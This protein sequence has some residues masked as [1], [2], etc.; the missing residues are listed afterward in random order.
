MYIVY[1]HHKLL[2]LLTSSSDIMSFSTPSEEFMFMMENNKN[3]TQP[4]IFNINKRQRRSTPG[5]IDDDDENAVLYIKYGTASQVSDIASF[6]ENPCMPQNRVT[7]TAN[8][9]PVI[10]DCPRDSENNYNLNPQSHEL[11]ADHTTDIEA[12]KPYPFLPFIRIINAKYE[13]PTHGGEVLDMGSTNLMRG[14]CSMNGIPRTEPLAYAGVVTMAANL[15]TEGRPGGIIVNT[16]GAVTC[17]NTGPDYLHSGQGVYLIPEPLMFVDNLGHRKPYIHIPGIPDITALPQTIAINGTDIANTFQRTRDF[18][19]RLVFPNIKQ[20]VGAYS[21]FLTKRVPEELRKHQL[22]PIHTKA[23][24]C[25]G[26]LYAAHMLWTQFDTDKSVAIGLESVMKAAHD[27]NKAAFDKY[28]IDL[29]E[30]ETAQSDRM[31]IKS[32]FISPWGTLGAEHYDHTTTSKS[33]IHEVNDRVN[34]LQHLYI[35][36]FTDELKPWYMG[37]VLVGGAS[38]ET[39]DINLGAA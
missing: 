10:F 33:L 35:F 12:L 11:Y 34:G 2:F 18:I 16:S 21:E 13:H 9:A 36:V 3:G 30:E 5:S 26:L 4:E 38:R 17:I 23:L 28:T 24:F 31:N 22:F 39:F 7:F 1:H 8:G 6:N 32:T 20:G 15:A 25:Y 27:L 19:C 37:R 29:G 14:R